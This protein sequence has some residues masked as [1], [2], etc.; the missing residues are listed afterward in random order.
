ML[1]I[2]YFQQYFFYIVSISFIG[3]GNPDLSQITVKVVSSTP[4]H[5]QGWNS[6]LY[7]VQLPNEYY[8]CKQNKKKYC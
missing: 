8:K 2:K 6:Q 3:G 1:H 4:L 7:M 5:E